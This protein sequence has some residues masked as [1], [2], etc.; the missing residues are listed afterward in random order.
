MK[1]KPKISQSIWEFAGDFIRLGDTLEQRQSNLNAACS[2]WNI[3]CN[4]PGVRKKSL[5]RY[6][7][8]F[9]GYNPNADQQRLA[10]VRSDMEH[11]IEVK[12]QMFPGDLRQ[13]VSARI[14]RSGDKERI[15]AAAASLS[16]PSPCD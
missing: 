6:M 7:R 9:K 1:P 10:D 15:E 13:I 8:S 16:G 2:A 14:F 11:L 12:L 4:H 5:D 3:A